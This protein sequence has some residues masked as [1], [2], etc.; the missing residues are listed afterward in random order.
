MCKIEF[1]CN[2]SVF[3]SVLW[4]FYYPGRLSQT[5]VE[6][7]VFSHLCHCLFLFVLNIT[8]FF[9][10]GIFLL[11]LSLSGIVLASWRGYI[12]GSH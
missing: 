8:I 1:S 11:S 12:G 7:G 2:S 10:G 9:F 4:W 5:E 3:S 6:L